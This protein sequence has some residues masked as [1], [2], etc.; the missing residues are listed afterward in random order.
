MHQGR[1]DFDKIMNK[2]RTKIEQFSQEELI[3]LND[4]K[5]INKDKVVIK[6]VKLLSLCCEN[7]NLPFQVIF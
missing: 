1:D 7:C 2:K 4:D 3:A 6:I 5:L